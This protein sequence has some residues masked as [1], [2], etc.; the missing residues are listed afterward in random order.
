MNE[1]KFSL[2]NIKKLFF[3]PENDVCLFH[4]LHIFQRI[5]KTTFIIAANSK[6]PDQTD[7]VSSFDFMNLTLLI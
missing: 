7:V 4:L 3:G 1:N 2:H 5:L 6:N